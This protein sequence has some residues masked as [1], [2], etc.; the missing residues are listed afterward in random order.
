MSIAQELNR[1]VL[2]VD[3]DLKDHSK[4]H[5]KFAKDFFGIDMS[6]G[7]TDYL[8]GN[9]KIS[10]ILLNPGIE[11]LVIIPS[12]KTLT[13][14]AELLS[15]PKMVM[16]VDDVKNRYPSDRIIIFD[17]SALLAFSDSLVLTRYVDGILLVVEEKRTSTEDIKKAMELLKDKPLLGSVISKIR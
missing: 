7:L 4:D 8:L 16:L 13:N 3:C 1:T 17:C 9:A 5:K 12:G 15:S 6:K 10:E 2:I 11:R 14:S